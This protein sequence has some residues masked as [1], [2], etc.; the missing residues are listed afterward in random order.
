MAMVRLTIGASSGPHRLNS[1]RS[2]DSSWLKVCRYKWPMKVLLII[3]MLLLSPSAFATSKDLTSCKVLLE[4]GLT[5]SALK[6]L[7]A[8]GIEDQDAISGY[9]ALTQIELE[10]WLEGQPP[11]APKLYLP[12]QLSEAEQEVSKKM[13]ADIVRQRARDRSLKMTVKLNTFVTALSQAVENVEPSSQDKRFKNYDFNQI[14]KAAESANG[15]LVPRSRSLE[16]SKAFRRLSSEARQ[17]RI[18]PK[19]LHVEGN[20]SQAA[21][22]SLFSALP[23]KAGY[24][25]A[26]NKD[27]TAGS[28]PSADQLVGIEPLGGREFSF[29]NLIE[30]D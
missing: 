7:F 29:L 16:S 13:R 4:A 14:L 9:L 10:A 24:I 19:R 26:V 3:G 21:I 25:L 28:T 27:Y 20:T 12:A 30:N 15:I 11:I 2:L 6:K 17:L 8:D 23:V 18:N 22:V 5:K 1:K